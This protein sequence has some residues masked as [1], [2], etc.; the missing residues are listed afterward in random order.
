MKLEYLVVFLLLSTLFMIT[1]FPVADSATSVPVGIAST[2]SYSWGGEYTVNTSLVSGYNL[3]QTIDDEGNATLQLNAILVVN[4]VSSTQTFLLQN[5]IRFK[6]EY[7]QDVDRVINITSGSNYIRAVGKGSIKGNVYCY[8]G[9]KGVISLPLLSVINI[10]I[11]KVNGNILIQFNNSNIGG[12]L[13]QVRLQISSLS[14][15]IYVNDS[16][17]PSGYYYDVEM[18]WGGTGGAIINFLDLN[19]TM[20]L[21]Y[22]NR[23]VLIAFPSVINYGLNTLDRA[24]GLGVSLLGNGNADVTTSSSYTPGYLTNCFMPSGPGFEIVRVVNSEQYY[25]NGKTFS[26]NNT[27]AFSSPFLL[28][29]SISKTVRDYTL[30][31]YYLKVFYLNNKTY[32]LFP[33]NSSFTYIP[34]LREIVYTVNETLYYVRTPTPLLGYINGILRNITSGFY[35]KG[36]NIT[37]IPEQVRNLTYDERVALIPIP[38]SL[39]LT[40]PVNV[41]VGSELQYY[42]EVISPIPLYAIYNGNN[43]SLISGWYNNGSVLTI[44]N[45][46]YYVTSNERYVISRVL[47][48]TSFSVEAPLVV[49]ISVVKQVFVRFLPY[50]Y[51]QAKVNGELENISNGWYN[52][53]T[54]I[55]IDPGIYTFNATRVIV[56]STVD[57][58]IQRPINITIPEKVLF[59]VTFQ[60]PLNVLYN[61]TEIK[62]DSLWVYN[63]S[64]VTIEKGYVSLGNGERIYVLT[65]LQLVVTSPLTPKIKFVIQYYVNVSKQIPAYINGTLGTLVS[66]WYNSNT[67]INIVNISLIANDIREV[68]IAYPSYF[69]VNKPILVIVSVTYQDYVNVSSEIK[70]YAIINGNETVFK[71]GWYNNNTIVRIL[72]YTSYS[73]EYKPNPMLVII[74]HPANIIVNWNIYYS[75]TINNVTQWYENGTVLR[76]ALHLPF[77]ERAELIGT[78]NVSVEKSLLVNQPLIEHVRIFI[79]Y[80]SFIFPTLLVILALI[81]SLFAK[82]A[83]EFYEAQ[84]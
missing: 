59:K 29:V 58:L 19:D 25:V 51:I 18:V 37:F 15:Y 13:D 27:F 35:L 84:Q 62:A 7:F 50:K 20:A 56:N 8:K 57:I 6:G 71:S 23:G 47:P 34:F 82:R 68:V 65:P 2:G 80:N 36:T 24:I 21:Y 81:L 76:V 74:T 38:S 79:D 60:Y 78:E 39:I 44:Q 63:D 61:G 9:I 3:I 73:S 16:R 42:I 72:S 52:L 49:N 10:S 64:T 26:G 22:L 28:N 70:P 67:T 48:T 83:K 41:T 46:S 31:T 32:N 66:G 30:Y 4:T 54:T 14:S 12:I 43:I 1:S 75:V 77:Y 11:G 17:T 5:E 33:G 45:I 40:S 55:V 69:L 53:D